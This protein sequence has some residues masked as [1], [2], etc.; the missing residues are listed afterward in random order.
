MLVRVT[1]SKRATERKA[2]ALL[3]GRFPG[4]VLNGGEH[5][6]PSR[7]LSF[8]AN[9][10]IPFTVHGCVPLARK[11][12]YAIDEFLELSPKR[13]ER[14]L[15]AAAERARH[16]YETNSDLNLELSS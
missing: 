10:S 6:I 12:R 15:R 4:T 5:L 14:I 3:L 1:F 7:A 9:H 13:R 8:L 2:L 16:E 11:R